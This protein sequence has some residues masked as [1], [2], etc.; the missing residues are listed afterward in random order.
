[1]Y[2]LFYGELAFHFRPIESNRD[3]FQLNKKVRAFENG[4]RSLSSVLFEGDV[5]FQQTNRN[6]ED[7]TIPATNTYLVHGIEL[8]TTALSCHLLI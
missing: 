7:E 2:F 3:L 4:L 5:P 6:G 1:M 8:S